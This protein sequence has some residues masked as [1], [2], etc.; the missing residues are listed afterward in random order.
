MPISGAFL[1]ISSRVP[2]K[3]ALPRG[4]Q[5]GAFSEGNAL[6]LGPPLSISQS[7]Q[8]TSPL[9]VPQQGPY[10]NRCPSPEPLVPVL[11]GPQ[12]GSSPSRFPSQSSHRQTHPTSRASFS[13]PSKFPVD[14]PTPGC[15][16][17]PHEE[18]CPSPEPSFHNPGSPVKE[19]SLKVLC[20]EPL[21][22]DMLHS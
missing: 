11:Q 19:P 3:G 1:N 2:S 8:E 17:E 14:K 22:R 15:P 13:H 18:R 4:P 10:G 6:F 16:A 9:Q 21:Q 20:S 5:Y 12:Q 7:S